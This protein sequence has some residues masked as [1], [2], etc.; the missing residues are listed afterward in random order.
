MSPAASCSLGGWRSVGGVPRAV[1]VGHDGGEVPRELARAG[2]RR[3]ADEIGGEDVQQ[4]EARALLGGVLGREQRAP[5]HAQPLDQPRDEDVGGDSVELG[6]GAAVQ[7]DEALDAFARL[8]RHLRGLGDGGEPGDEVE[9]APAGD[10]DDAGEL[11]LAQ[12]DGGP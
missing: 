7:L 6:G 4:L 8:G 2:A 11:D 5:A 12:L 1:R 10:L 9:L 3:S